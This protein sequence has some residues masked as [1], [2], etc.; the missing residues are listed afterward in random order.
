MP[1]SQI[2]LWLM[3]MNEA[4][5][6]AQTAATGGFALPADLAVALAVAMAVAV[7]AVTTW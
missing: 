5:Q 4:Q 3:D 1:S 2:A 7:A 6:S